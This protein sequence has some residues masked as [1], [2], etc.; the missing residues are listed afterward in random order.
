MRKLAAF[1]FSLSLLPAAPTEH[2]TLR[3]AEE[4]ALKNHPA[5]QSAAAVERASLEITKEMRSRYMPTVEGNITAAGTVS[6][7]SRIFAGFLNA[8][9]LYD[10]VGLGVTVSQLISDFGRTGNL[11]SS[12]GLRAQAQGQATNTARAQILL[13]VDQS[14]FSVLRT[15]AVLR[16]AEQTVAARQLV[17]DQVTTLA[18]SKLKSQLDVTFARVNLE[19]ARLLLSSAQND[20]RSALAAFSTALG[21]DVASDYE[22]AEEP[23]PSDLPPDSLPLVDLAYRQRPEARQADL[24]LQ[25]AERFARAERA[26]SYPTLSAVANAGGA[27]VHPDQFEAG[28]GAAGINLQIPVF[29]GGLFSARRAEAEARTEAARQVAREVHNRIARDVRVA[30]LAARDAF[31]RLRLTAELLAEAGESLKLAQARYDLGLGS[32]VELSQAQLN[33]TRA[34]IAQ[35]SAKFDYQTQRSVLSFESGDLK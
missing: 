4:I 9:S 29:N 22:L 15:R 25:A 28:W 11:Y 31:E 1:L 8:P 2:L 21:T 16:V 26:L 17:A 7:T 14:Y 20:Q 18:Q 12:A 5:L 6:E 35:A 10:H 3:Q 30:Y 27:P 24:E 33:V 19:E 32:I 34:Q 23:V 13:A